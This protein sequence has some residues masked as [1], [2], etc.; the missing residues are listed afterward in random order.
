MIEIFAHRAIYENK[1]NSLEGIEYCLKSSFNVEIDVR[2]KDE[3][4][5]LSHDPQ[6]NGDLF[7]MA[8]EI[9]KRNSKKAAIHIK[10]SF[11]IKNLVDFIHEY[12]IEKK[13]FI[14]S[15][16]Q[17]YDQ[18]KKFENIKYAY[19]QNKFESKT[20]AK[21]LWCDESN[22]VWYDQKTFS[23]HK[24]NNRTIITMSKE[25]LKPCEIGEIR[26]EWNRLIDL[27][28]DGICTDFPLL[29][30]EYLNEKGSEIN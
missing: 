26:N 8:C 9:I 14:F 29:L 2:K 21:I 22:E 25:L 7:Y 23:E 12:N 11:D 18:L 27:K 6:E 4:F 20:D 3:S 30:K 5:Y 28:V 24:K 17:D 1:D 10:E 19:Y 13:C 15:I 16:L